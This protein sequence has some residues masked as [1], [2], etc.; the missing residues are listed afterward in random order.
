MSLR[1]QALLPVALLAAGCGTP[2]IIQDASVD[3]GE[4]D[5]GPAKSEIPARPGLSGRVY[6]RAGRPFVAELLL[7][8]SDGEAQVAAREA[9]NAASPMPFEGLGRPLDVGVAPDLTPAGYLLA[10]LPLYDALDGVCG[11]GTLTSSVGPTED[12]YADLAGVLADDR[13]W[14]DVSE[15]RTTC[16]TF[17][18][19]ERRAF[20]L[21]A[22]PESDCGGRAPDVDALDA[23][24]EILT[25]TAAGDGVEV[26]PTTLSPSE[27]FF[28]LP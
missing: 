20:G 17:F 4:V 26:D 5:A 8:R 23:M 22:P 11:E 15:R 13:I 12:R 2:A 9:Y 10:D 21:E 18:A 19:V 6:D 7:T 28:D 1:L 24:L 14:L 27:P 16:A 25:A 3:A